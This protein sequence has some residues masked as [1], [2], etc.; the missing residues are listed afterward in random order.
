MRVLIV[1]HVSSDA[2]DLVRREDLDPLPETIERIKT[3][4]NQR[5]LVGTR[6]VVEPPAYRGITVVV[7]IALL[8]GFSREQAKNDVLR[9][10]NGLLHP[11]KGGPDG[12][13]WPIGRAVQVHEVTAALARIPGVNMAEKVTVQLFP[14]DP[15][16]GQRSREP[17]DVISLA[18]NELVYTYG[19]HSVRVM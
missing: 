2:L 15:S 13:G 12:T 1:P 14:V 3:H 11:L 4:L 6:L 17:V 10:L 7:T 19:R 16:T 5:R 8:P 18:R 9:A